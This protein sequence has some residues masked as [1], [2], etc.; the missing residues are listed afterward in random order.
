MRKIQIQ[1]QE[2]KPMR[3]IR[4]QLQE[5]RSLRRIRIR[6]HRFKPA[7]FR[8]HL[9][10][11]EHESVEGSHVSSGSE[12]RAPAALAR[13]RTANSVGKKPFFFLNPA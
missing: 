2:T 11:K 9:V 7:L 12:D 1:L 5:I 10:E 13:Y 3:S 8:Y 6:K 4:I